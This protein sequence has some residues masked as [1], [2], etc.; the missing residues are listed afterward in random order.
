MQLSRDTSRPASLKILKVPT[1]THDAASMAIT[2]CE[3]TVPS[4]VLS[5][6]HSV[7]V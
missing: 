7:V 1:V 2:S 6:L 5:M 3:V 4:R